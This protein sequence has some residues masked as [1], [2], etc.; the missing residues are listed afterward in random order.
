[1]ADTAHW[2]PKHSQRS[3][4]IRDLD[5]S[6]NLKMKSQKKKLARHLGININKK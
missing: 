1:M 3:K 5:N 4:V 6:K 2:K